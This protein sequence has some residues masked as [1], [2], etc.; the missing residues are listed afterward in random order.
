MGLTKKYKFPRRFSRG[1]CMRKTCKKMG[2]TEKASCRPYKNCYM[3]GGAYNASKPRFMYLGPKRNKS[4]RTGRV[5]KNMGNYIIG[6]F[7]YPKIT[8]KLRKNYLNSMGE[9]C[10]KA[11][12]TCGC[13]PSETA[14][15]DMPRNSTP[16]P[17]APPTSPEELN[18]NEDDY[19]NTQRKLEEKR[20]YVKKKNEYREYRSRRL[21]AP[22]SYYITQKN[23]HTA[24]L[25]TCSALAMDIHNEGVEHFLTHISGGESPSEIEEMISDIKSRCSSASSDCIHNIKIWAGA[26]SE[27]EAGQELNDP[28]Y[29]S[30]PVVMKV[31]E[32]LDLVDVRDGKIYYKGTE[33]EIPVIKTCFRH[34]VGSKN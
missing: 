34:Y 27:M 24:S 7:N 22:G 19:F 11:C 32:G 10:K 33:T 2:F 5:I 12:A 28:N 4:G 14:D 25:V 23:V 30:M 18:S 31:L 15:E 8:R 21:V 3:K 1:H 17:N 6:Q 20:K 26:G 29:V 13:I 16:T 9:P